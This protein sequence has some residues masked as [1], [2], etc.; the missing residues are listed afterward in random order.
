MNYIVYM[1]DGNKFICTGK[2][3][4]KEMLTRHGYEVEDINEVVEY[5]KMYFTISEFRK[6]FE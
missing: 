4:V 3:G 5:S 2:D 6:L 1:I